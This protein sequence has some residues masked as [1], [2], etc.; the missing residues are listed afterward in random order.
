MSLQS[1]CSISH[2]ASCTYLSDDSL[3]LLNLT[4]HPNN[5]EID[6]RTSSC[7]ATQKK[8]LLLYIAEMSHDQQK[9]LYNVKY[10]R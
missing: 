9:S 6:V 10:F 3:L 5:T 4:T 8:K 1:L 2:L 7:F